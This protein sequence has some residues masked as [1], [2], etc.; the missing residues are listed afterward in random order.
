MKRKAFFSFELCIKAAV[1]R[2]SGNFW[3]PFCVGKNN[4]DHKGRPRKTTFSRRKRLV[5]GRWSSSRGWLSCHG[6]MSATLARA[7]AIFLL[8]QKSAKSHWISWHCPVKAGPLEAT[9]VIFGRSSLILCVW[10]ILEKYENDTTFV[11]MRSSDHLAD[12]KMSKKA[13]H[14]VEFYLYY[15]L[16]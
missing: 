3:Q 2:L 12:A 6:L 8:T 15:Q 10:K 14:F 5:F 4:G 11:R 1:S 7:V 13:P 16:R 9:L